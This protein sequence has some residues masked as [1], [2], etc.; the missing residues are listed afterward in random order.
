MKYVMTR[1][2]DAIVQ[3]RF[4]MRGEFG[5]GAISFDR[6]SR[7]NLKASIVHQFQVLLI[8]LREG[9]LP[10]AMRISGVF[11][12]RADSIRPNKASIES[13]HETP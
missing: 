11:F 5:T 6:R 8:R 4:E 13:A 9:T 7:D 3:K 1:Q 12:N 10:A 2:H